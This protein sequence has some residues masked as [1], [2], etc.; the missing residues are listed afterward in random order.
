MKLKELFERK[1]ELTEGEW[2]YWSPDSKMPDQKGGANLGG[3][4]V[5]SF[6]TLPESVGGDL[7]LSNNKFK[8]LKNIHKH[9]KNIKGELYLNQC[10][11]ESHVLGVLKIKNLTRINMDNK[12]IQK[13]LNKHLSGDRDVLACQN[14]LMDAGFEEFA[15]L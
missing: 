1:I 14:D 8:S 5:N 15:Q 13:I 3:L 10:P 11:I 9:I 12:N 2:H 7:F 6:E 4:G